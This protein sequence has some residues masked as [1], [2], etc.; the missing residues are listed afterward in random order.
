MKKAGMF[1]LSLFAG[2]GVVFVV[3]VG[4]RPTLNVLSF[5]WRVAK[6]EEDLQWNKYQTLSFQCQHLREMAK[7]QPEEYEEIYP[8]GPLG[9]RCDWGY[10]YEDYKNWKP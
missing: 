4:W 10:T 6:I 7:Y 8:Y 3:S 5:P 1:I 9:Y 2:I